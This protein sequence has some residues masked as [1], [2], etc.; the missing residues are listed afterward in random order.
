[1]RLSTNVLL[2]IETM[3]VLRMP[4]STVRVDGATR[5]CALDYDHTLAQVGIKLDYRCLKKQEQECCH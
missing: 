5:F 4:T 1:M 3:S 2:L